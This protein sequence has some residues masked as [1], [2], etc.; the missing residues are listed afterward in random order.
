MVGMTDTELLFAIETIKQL[1]ARYFRCVDIR[2]WHGFRNVFTD[3]VQFDISDDLPDGGLI[4][5]A[6]AVV[7][8]VSGT[9]NDGIVSVHH[10][11]CPEITVTSATTA[12]GIWA[13]EDMLFWQPDAGSPISTLHGYGHYIET[14]RKV[15]GDWRIHTMKLKRLRVDT[16]GWDNGQ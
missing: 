14:Y 12:E 1:K 4:I 13:M 9:L 15:A 2:D 8:L 6:D 5:G 11:H 3:D 16:R 7:V 10:G